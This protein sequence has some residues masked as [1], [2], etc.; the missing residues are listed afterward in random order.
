MVL[1]IL[2]ACVPP[3][4]V[5]QAATATQ[6]PTYTHVPTH[7]H[8]PSPTPEIKFAEAF[9]STIERCKEE[10]DINVENMEE[11]ISKI[12]TFEKS[13]G[14]NTSDAAAIFHVNDPSLEKGVSK[15]PNAFTLTFYRKEKGNE[16]FKF[17]SCFHLTFPD[18]SEA[19]VVG[20]PV[21]LNP[22]DSQVVF[23]HFANEPSATE[24]LFRNY[25]EQGIDYGWKN[26]EQL[27]NINLTYDKMRSGNFSKLSAVYLL[28][29]PPGGCAPYWDNMR[30]L[31]DIAWDKGL[32]EFLLRTSGWEIWTESER[33]EARDKIQ[34]IIIPTV[35][36]TITE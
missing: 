32:Y 17:S 7:T 11:G 36:I 23:L 19:Y 12:L 9:P 22:E 29:D 28:A 35:T 20:I 3:Q 10:N 31:R 30:Y 14:L 8:V 16:M 25:D 15:R 2:A 27:I 26:R 13:L 24:K 6:E 4:E 18:K 34:E 21:L 5:D 33:Q 1:F